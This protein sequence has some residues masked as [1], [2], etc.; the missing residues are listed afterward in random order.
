MQKMTQNQELSFLKGYP[1]IHMESEANYENHQSDQPI[2]QPT[3]E[4][5]PQ[6]YKLITMA[7]FEGQ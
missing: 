6:E 2:M 7:I 1:I 3:F 5:E 4:W